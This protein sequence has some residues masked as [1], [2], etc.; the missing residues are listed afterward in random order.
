[1]KKL[2]LLPLLLVLT[3]C[4]KFEQ[5]ARDTAAALGGAVTAAQAQHQTDCKAA[6]ATAPCVLINKG[7]DAQNALITGIEAY[8]GWTA[9]V[10][11]T[12][13]NAACKP[14]S[15]AQAGLQTAISNANVLIGQLKGIIQ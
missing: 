14:V 3:A 12:D 15:T 10:L 6:P 1:M 4:P 2:L 13:P 9:G 7:V 8:C 11:P 5:N